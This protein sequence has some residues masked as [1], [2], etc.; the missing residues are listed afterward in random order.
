MH[1]DKLPDLTLRLRAEDATDGLAVDIM[2]A[3]G[4]MSTQAT[5][6]AR[7]VIV[8]SAATT[9]SPPTGYTPASMEAKPTHRLVRV[10]EVN[11]PALVVPRVKGPNRNPS[12]LGSFGAPPYH[13]LLPL[14]MLAAAHAV[15]APTS[16]APP[17]TTTAAAAPTSA[18]TPLPPPPTASNAPASAGTPP[19]FDFTAGGGDGDDGEPLTEHEIARLQAL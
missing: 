11:L 7:A 15:A 4:S 19:P 12:T 6:A 5:R 13:F 2:P 3:H 10:T 17:S 16:A 9:W 1:L 8:Q 18:T 14:T